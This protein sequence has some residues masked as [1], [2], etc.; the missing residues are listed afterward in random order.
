MATDKRVFTLRLQENNFNKIKKIAELN[1][2]STAMQI[3]FIIELFIKD[4]EKLN[5]KI[6]S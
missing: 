4:Y 5:G 2:R 6:E 1:K 3:E